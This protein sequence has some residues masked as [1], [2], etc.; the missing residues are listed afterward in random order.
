[1]GSSNSLLAHT[2][3][4]E[5][6]KEAT[7]SS[8]ELFAAEKSKDIEVFIAYDLGVSSALIALIN[9]INK[10]LTS[11]KFS[12][13]LVTEA[14]KSDPSVVNILE[15]SKCVVVCCTESYLHIIN[16][17]GGVFNSSYEAQVVSILQTRQESSIIPII[18]E[19]SLVDDDQ[20]WTGPVATLL[21]T[22][23]PIDCSDPAVLAD[24]IE[25]LA[26]R[27]ISVFTSS[28]AQLIPSSVSMDSSRT[29]MRG[30]VSASVAAPEDFSPS[31]RLGASSRPAK[32]FRGHS[33]YV[34]SVVWSPNGEYIASVSDDETVRI[35]DAFNGNTIRTFDSAAYSSACF[36]PDSTLITLGSLRSISI[37]EFLTGRQVVKFSEGI[38]DAV[39]SLCWRPD[40]KFLA[41]TVKDSKVAFV[42]SRESGTCTARLEGHTR[43]VN[44]IAYAPCG[45]Y[46]S[47]GSG[48]KSVR[49]WDGDEL[50]CLKILK[51]H[52]M[53]VCS[54]TWSPDSQF[55][56]SGSNDKTLRL[57]NSMSGECVNVL[58]GH[59][60][61]V[62]SV[63]YSTNGEH[64]CSGSLDKTIRI[65]NAADGRLI[66]VLEGHTNEIHSV[67]WS[68]DGQFIASGS[69]DKTI[70]M[71]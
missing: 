17:T 58:T 10:E 27:L 69:S 52:S 26:D 22:C 56:V 4:Y 50:H 31:R 45:K 24:A 61:S 40:G 70:G 64:I 7:P 53:S 1:M 65:W 37:V 5:E 14:A 51:G 23:Q 16:H 38:T 49:I 60:A 67:A 2:P 29:G 71:W 39:N 63:A 20:K 42:W 33:D 3:H 6:A 43:R 21:K 55:V 13:Y 19:S 30:S 46:V 9:S 57:W 35:W 41:H 54:I 36:S 12:T 47:T 25:L 48:D 8:L 32:S 28:S 11:S 66:N 34:I 15:E 68:H 59:T 62:S 44:A 18:L